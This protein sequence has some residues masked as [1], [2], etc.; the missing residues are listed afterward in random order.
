VA[1][2][3]AFLLDPLEKTR[4]DKFGEVETLNGLGAVGMQET[5]SRSSLTP[6]VAIPEPN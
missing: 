3:H 2:A 1:P 4:V 6:G 5:I